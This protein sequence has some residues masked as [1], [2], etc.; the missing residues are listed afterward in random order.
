MIESAKNLRDI[1]TKSASENENQQ[2]LVLVE[3]DSDYS[4]DDNDLTANSR[5]LSISSIFIMSKRDT[6][7]S[8]MKGRNSLKKEQDDSGRAKILRVP[9]Y[10]S[11]GVK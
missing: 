3:I 8:A 4:E 10:I 6:L 2:V 1:F 9:I 5:A 11:G 7:G